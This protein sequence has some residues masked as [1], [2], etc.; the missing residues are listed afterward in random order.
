MSTKISE[1][2]EFNS[3]DSDLWELFQEDFADF[4]VDNFKSLGTAKLQQLRNFLKCGGVRAP[5]ATGKITNVPLVAIATPAPTESTLATNPHPVLPVNTAHS[6]TTQP[7]TV[8]QPTV[9]TG[10]GRLITDV[11]RNYSDDQKYDGTNG[12]F[13]LK[14]IIFRSICDRVELP[15]QALA[16]AF[17]VMLKGL[18]LNQ[19]FNDQL[20]NRNEWNS[21]DLESTTLANPG[22]TIFEVIQLLINKLRDIQY[23]LSPSL[24]T[25]EFFH[26]KLIMACQ[27]SPACKYAVSDPPADLGQV[28]NKLKSSITKY[29]KER[30][31][32]LTKTEAYFTDHRYYENQEAAGYV[33][34]LVVDH[35]STLK[36]N[37]KQKK[38]NSERKICPNFKLTPAILTNFS[39]RNLNNMLWNTKEILKKK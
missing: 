39:T 22:K 13:D 10:S 35:G 3:T 21:I 37:K 34:N 8:K 29:E 2:K 38:P 19:Y 5:K 14:L 15:E 17:P 36:A 6:S 4:T 18:A 12:S 31:K 11:T 24:R 27:S 28:I 7:T 20:S 26:D 1:N 30:E 9:A 23:G 25:P 33:E 16:K 32:E